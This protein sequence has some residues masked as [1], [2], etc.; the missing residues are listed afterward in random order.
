MKPMLG[1][2]GG[3]NR[4]GFPGAVQL[5]KLGDAFTLRRVEDAAGPKERDGLLDPVTALRSILDGRF[6]VRA[7]TVVTGAPDVRYAEK[8]GLRSAVVSSRCLRI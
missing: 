6:A 8:S 5:G 4:P 2:M 1:E 3:V 7:Q